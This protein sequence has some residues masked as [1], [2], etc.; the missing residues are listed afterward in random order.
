MS[1]PGFILA[2]VRQAPRSQLTRVRFILPRQTAK[3]FDRLARRVAHKNRLP[4]WKARGF[5][6][7]MLS[8]G[9]VGHGFDRK[10]IARF[11]F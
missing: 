11:G 6:V 7:A 5:V 3:A 9:L 2:E 8:T 4:L 1:I 10:A